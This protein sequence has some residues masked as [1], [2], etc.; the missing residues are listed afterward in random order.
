MLTIEEYRVLNTCADGPE[1]FYYPFA[2][3][4]YGSPIL[5]VYNVTPDQ[6]AGADREP[7]V[8]GEAVARII[9]GLIRAGLLQC[10]RAPRE[11][12]RCREVSEPYEQEFAVY[13]GY[14]CLSWQDHI[15]CFG[16]GPHEFGVTEAG[17]E[18]I[19][20]PIYDRYDRELGW[21]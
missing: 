15:E 3:L 5:A 2:E 12:E 11:A 17:L 16:Y 4:N 21:E 6:K 13:A 19:R 1:L 20:K 14:D 9:T 7:K 10:C 8:S 18:E